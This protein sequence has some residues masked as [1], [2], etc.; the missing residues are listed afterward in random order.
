[1][2]NNDFQAWIMA[3]SQYR[4][5]SSSSQALRMIAPNLNQKNT[6][7]P[8]TLANPGPWYVTRMG[9]SSCRSGA[10]DRLKGFGADA[11]LLHLAACHSW[12]TRTTLQYAPPHSSVRRKRNSQVQQMPHNLTSSFQVIHSFRGRVYTSAVGP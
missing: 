2:A 6:K 11:L 12:Q 10:L 8:R 3:L 5:R 1:M 4:S 9:S 7:K